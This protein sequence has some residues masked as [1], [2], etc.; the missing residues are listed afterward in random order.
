[1]IAYMERH[2]VYYFP[3]IYFLGSRQIRE[4]EQTRLVESI[5]RDVATV[6]FGG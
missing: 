5:A 4:Q 3:E 1:M 2:S 6:L